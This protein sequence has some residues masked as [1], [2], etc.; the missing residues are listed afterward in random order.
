M[1]PVI[2]TL[3]PNR[4]QFVGTFD[5][6]NYKDWWLSSPLPGAIDHIISNCWVGGSIHTAVCYMKN[7]SYS[8][9]QS[10]NYGRDW[11]E[12]LNIPEQIHQIE[13]IDFGWILA[14]TAAGWLESTDSATT[15]HVISTQ[16]PGCKTVVNIGEDI[17][18]AHDGNKIWK[19]I[20]KGR[21]W[22]QVL[23]C[24]NIVWQNFHGGQRT[25]TWTGDVYPALAGV[26]NRILAGCGPYLL[27]SENQ[28]STW[29]MPWWYMGDPNTLF[30]EI[31]PFNQHRVMQILHSDCLGTGPED[32][33]FLIRI[34]H[35]HDG[36]VR[37]Y[38]ARQVFTG[39]TA[40]FDQY[41]SEAV[42]AN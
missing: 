8:I 4:L 29:T 9:Y 3:L 33:V 22:S 7:G 37:H 25:T 42:R 35:I 18:L 20:D 12:V 39:M 15:F 27:I 30:P 1:Q 24:H 32:N 34:H 26:Y 11:S 6:G 2:L 5:T 17:F 14:S 23:D 40:R 41:Y 31:L 16:A 36:I 13:Q 38:Y 21:N 28:G 19:S 10:T